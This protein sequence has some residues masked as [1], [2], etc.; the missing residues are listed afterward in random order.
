[1]HKFYGLRKI[2]VDIGSGVLY[3]STVP[4]QRMKY[5]T[6]ANDTAMKILATAKELGWDVAVRGSILTIYK[7][8][9][10]DKE[11][12]CRA[13]SEYFSILGLLPSTSPGSIWGTD[14]GG[15]GA[16][17]AMSSRVFKMNKSGGSKRVLNALVKM[18]L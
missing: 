16:L 9:I 12:F 14:G 1:M 13:D 8:G 7:D 10:N 5:M 11:A 2:V 18:T 15:I 3:K 4:K 17:S 6:T